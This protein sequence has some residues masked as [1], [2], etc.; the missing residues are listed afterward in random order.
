MTN[1]QKSYTCFALLAADMIASF[2]FGMYQYFFGVIDVVGA[3]M[4]FLYTFIFGI[5]PC[6]IFGFIYLFSKK[7]DEQYEEKIEKYK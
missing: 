1:K 7:G 3:F 5:V 2:L 6:L 4:L